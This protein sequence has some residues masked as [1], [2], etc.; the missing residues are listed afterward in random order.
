MVDSRSLAG[1]DRKFA[2]DE[3]MASSG[4]PTN[5]NQVATMRYVCKS[6]FVNATDADQNWSLGDNCFDVTFDLQ[7]TRKFYIR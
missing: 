3:I 1:E 7:A 2:C 4:C 6:F 5:M